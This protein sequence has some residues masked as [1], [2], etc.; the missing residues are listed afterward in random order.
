VVL[1]NG[2]SFAAP[3][4]IGTNDAYGLVLRAGGASG[5]VL[6]PLVGGIT[7]NLL[8]GTYYTYTAGV[9]GVFIGAGGAAL[10]S[11]PDVFNEGPHVITDSYAFIGGGSNNRAGN[12]NGDVDDAAFATVVGGNGN[13]A[14]RLA[15]VGGGYANTAGDSAVVG[16]GQDNQATGYQSTVAGGQNNDATAYGG[17]VGG[18]RFNTATGTMATVPGGYWNEAS[19]G[20]SFAAGRRAKAPGDGCFV[21]GDSTDAD[22]TCAGANRFVARATGG[23]YFYTGLG[24]TTGVSLL[25]GDS[26]W[27]SLSDRAAKANIEPVDGVEIL[28]RL[29]AVPVSTWNYS[30]T[31]PKLRHIGPMA[32]DFHAA[33]G[34]G[35]D[36]RYIATVDAQGVALAAIQGL[37]TLVR[38]KDAE[39]AALRR[40]MDELRAEVR[41][42]AGQTPPR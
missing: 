10:N 1:Q 19:G 21:W 4:F 7:A 11:D 27:N 33:F 15:F 20:Y 3:M 8:G 29:D 41:R 31:S 39:L 38:A 17:S 25:A 34:V 12:A 13:V 37:H 32:Q 14:E 18:G 24:P 5:L 6:T 40:E 36:P 22:V 2:N 9:R 23:V 35:G 30:T 28:E 16:G 26:T 42:I